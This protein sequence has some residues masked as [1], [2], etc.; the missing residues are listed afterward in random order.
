[1]LK[2]IY[3]KASSGKTYTIMEKIKE[4][5]KNGVPC[6]LIVPEQFTFENE[7]LVLKAIGDSAALNVKVLS[8]SRLCDELNRVQG[9]SAAKVLGNYDRIIF[10]KRALTAVQSELK[11]WQKYIKNISFA[12]TMLDTV[13]EFKMSGITACELRETANE[14]ENSALRSKLEDIATISEAYDLALAQ[15]YI[16]PT[17]RLTKLVNDLKESDYFTGKVVFIDS[18]KGFT[19]QQYKIISQILSKAPNVYVSLTNDVNN[20]KGYNVFANIQ[21]MAKK[22][23]DIAKASAVKVEEPIILNQCYYKNKSLSNLEAL[24]AGEDIAENSDG[25]AVTLCRANT[26]AD[27]AQFVASTIRRLVREENYRYRDFV[28]IA[29]DADAYRQTV[30]SACET[31][32]VKCFYDRRISMAS[33]PLSRFTLAAI[34]ALRLSTEGI[35][36][37]NK[38]GLGNLTFEEISLLEN[39]AYLWNVNGKLWCEE[40]NMDPRGFVT[41]PLDEENI[42]QLEKLNALR[43][44]ALA[45]ILTLK[46]NFKGS[47]RNRVEALIKLYDQCGCAQKLREMCDSFDGVNPY[48]SADMLVQSYDELMHIFD[49]MVNSL[50]EEAVDREA[51]RELLNLALNTGDIGVIPQTLDEVTFGSADRIR[52]SRP[53]VAFVLGA[54][55]G[56]FPKTVRNSGILSLSERK[57]LVKDFNIIIADNSLESVIDEEFLVYSNLCC[58]SEKL[59]VCCNS[60]SLVGEKAEPS[61]FFLT[62]EE[63][64]SCNKT[65]APKEQIDNENLPETAKAAFSEYCRKKRTNPQDAATLKEALNSS[66]YGDDIAFCDAF[67][68]E[69]PFKISE[70]NAKRLYGNDIRMSASRFDTYN[71]CHF[72]YFCK[73]GLSLK[74]LQPAE[75]DVMQRGTIVHFVLEKI[76]TDYKKELASCDKAVLDKLCDKCIAEYLDSVKGFRSVENKYTDF[77]VGRI[78]R[79]LKEVVLHVAK[80][81]AQSQFEPTDCELKI[82]GEGIPLELEHSSGKIIF[83]GSIDR[84]DKYEGYIRVIDYKTGSKTFKLPDILFGLNLQMLIYLYAVTR[85][86]GLPDT[87][88]AGILYQP[89]KRDINEKGL[90]MNGLLPADPVIVNAMEK[91]ALGEY[92][93]KMSYNRDGSVSMRSSSFVKNEVFSEIF[94]HIERIAKKTGDELL[95]GDIKISPVDGRESPA[96]KYCDFAS[97]CGI[98][99]KKAEKVPSMTNS[100]VVEELEREGENGT[101]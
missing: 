3:G 32:G 91:G 8:F 24:M 69:V 96:C 101:T 76:I 59:Y 43:E 80:E 58:P 92:V 28:I 86:S 75:F 22:I 77:L 67:T 1:M 39:Y 47:A 97:I 70:E 64:L 83:S 51:F 26:S 99:N 81:I 18:F 35:L 60:G 53:K 85:A 29:R 82:G 15:K 48:L 62:L 72:S 90:A 23:E 50:G 94:D 20:K 98:E 61:A 65:V 37:L 63:K 13:D 52:P 93:P 12:K 55:Q 4:Y 25:A 10:M 44:K 73:Y 78:S 56:V 27:E 42:K 19:G 16:D 33:F 2:F 21:K 100:Q 49:S 17:D 41:E 89:A 31:N 9:G 79:S 36:G 34:D 38:T 54:N 46:E 74:K 87:A 66:S 84:V 68:N 5:T 30:I 11:L 88:A 71:R 14:C 40:W 57:A 7:R 45:P 6:V 95:Q